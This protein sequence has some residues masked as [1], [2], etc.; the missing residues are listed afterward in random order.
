MPFQKGNTLGS[1]GNHARGFKCRNLKQLKNM[2]WIHKGEVAQR[3]SAKDLDKFLTQGWEHGR[4]EPSE[5]TRLK[6][7]ESQ[8]KRTGRIRALPGARRNT[9]YKTRYKRTIEDFDNK[10]AEQGDHCALCPSVGSGKR[11]LCW[12]HNHKCCHGWSTCGKCVRGLLCITCNRLVSHLEEWS[13]QGTLIPTPGTWLEKALA[14]LASYQPLTGEVESN[15][16][17]EIWQTS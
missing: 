15:S 10:F 2:R 6:Q 17:E 11:R 5:E 9:Q 7:S 13:A 3:V 1:H 16:E 8:K 14:Y 4:P 12:D